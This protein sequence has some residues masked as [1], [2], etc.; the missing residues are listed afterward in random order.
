M[1][2]SDNEPNKK[3]IRLAQ[4]IWDYMNID[5]PISKFPKCEVIIC[6]GSIDTLPAERAAQLYKNGI[7]KMVLLTGK[8]G[9]FPHGVSPNISEA[10][11][12]ADVAVIEGVPEV[13][14]LLEEKSTNTGEN[15]IFGSKL[16]KAKKIKVKNVAVTHMPSSLRRD[17]LTLL[18][19]WP[20]PQPKFYMSSPQVS[21]EN[22]CI[23]GYK[24]RLSLEYV[25]NSMLGDFQR[26]FIYAQKGFTVPIETAF[27]EPVPKRVKNAYLKLVE[28]GYGKGYLLRDN[29]GKPLKI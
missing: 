29:M 19:Q 27:G 7:S 2:I 21:L 10:R 26:C 17:Y 11:M 5:T 12:L 13:A 4:A 14:I 25:I 6:L 15:V 3:E 16:L 1:K 22:Y 24:E 23:R 9:P 28:I 8:S 20:D 18:K